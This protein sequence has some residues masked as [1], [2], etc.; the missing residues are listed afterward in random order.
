MKFVE[1]SLVFLALSTKKIVILINLVTKVVLFIKTV[2]KHNKIKLFYV[3]WNILTNRKHLNLN[4]KSLRKTNFSKSIILLIAYFLV[5]NILFWTC[6]TTP[7][8]PFKLLI[9]YF[10][11]IL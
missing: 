10:F 1:I 5:F 7:S 2:F 6:M 11:V 9:N 8:A 3:N 4:I